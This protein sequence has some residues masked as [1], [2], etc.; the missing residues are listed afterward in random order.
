M[1][2]IPWDLIAKV[3][4]DRIHRE[5]STLYDKEGDFSDGIRAGLI[6]AESIVSLVVSKHIQS[7]DEQ[8]VRGW[9][10][11]NT[12]LVAS[13]RVAGFDMDFPEQL[14]IASFVHL[15]NSIAFATDRTPNS[16]RWDIEGF[17]LPDDVER[18]GVTL[19]HA[20][21]FFGGPRDKGEFDPSSAS[22]AIANIAN[23]VRPI[24]NYNGITVLKFMKG[25]H[26]LD[27]E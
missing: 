22:Q 1:N 7:F 17:V 4:Q 6:R 27:C 2:I 26:D 15:C 14:T 23:R 13:A 25:R 11:E 3:Q 16:V 5:I 8:R 20:T 12:H 9:M 18:L 24:Y 21:T 19:H 10:R